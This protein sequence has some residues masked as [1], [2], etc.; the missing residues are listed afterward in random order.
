MYRWLDLWQ[1][2]EK[3]VDNAILNVVQKA[4]PNGISN[5]GKKTLSCMLKTYRDML[6]L[7]LRNDPLALVD[8]MEVEL[9]EEITPIAENTPL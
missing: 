9:K 6:S 3:E 2:C 5:T 4:G 8:A 7:C 1:D